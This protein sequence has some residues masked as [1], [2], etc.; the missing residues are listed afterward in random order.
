MRPYK[1]LAFSFP[2]FTRVLRPIFN[3]FLG[4]ILRTFGGGHYGPIRPYF[5]LILVRKALIWLERP[6]FP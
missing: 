5:G 6:Y 3:F 1:A 2:F 4:A